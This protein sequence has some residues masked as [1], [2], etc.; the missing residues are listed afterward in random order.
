MKI[1]TIIISVVL[2]V[3]NACSPSNIDICGKGNSY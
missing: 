3:F 1:S 2:L